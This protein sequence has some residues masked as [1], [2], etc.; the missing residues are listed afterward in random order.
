MADFTDIKTNHSGDCDQQE[1]FISTIEALVVR[2]AAVN[3]AVS[4]R[5][6]ERQQL[7]SNASWQLNVACWT[8]GDSR[9]ALG[10]DAH[11]A[12]TD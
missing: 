1:S 10:V 3:T 9:G 2:R 4:T 11:G 5:T 7:C 6:V 8:F 12:S